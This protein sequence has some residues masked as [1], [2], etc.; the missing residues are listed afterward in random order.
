MTSF[1]MPYSQDA[2]RDPL[3]VGAQGPVAHVV[4]GGIGGRGGGRQ[5]ARGN[6]GRAALADG[7]QEGLP[8][9]LLVVD[10]GLD[11]LAIDGGVTVVGVHR[12]RVVAPDGQLLDGS[13]R[14][15]GLGGQLRGGTVVV[16][17]QHGGEVLGRQVRRRLHRDVGVGVGG[18]A[19]DQHLDVARGDGVQRLAL[20]RED[21]A[22]DGQQ[23]GTL[24]ARAA[25]TRA[26]QQ[27]VVGVLEGAHR[28]AVGFHAGQ[29]REGAVL[30]LHDHA[31]Q[32][33]L[34]L[35][36][37]DLQQLQDDGLVLAQH[38]AGGDAEQQGVADLASSAGDGDANGFLAH[39]SLRGQLIKLTSRGAKR[40]A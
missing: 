35:L 17:A 32:C 3:A 36:V 31:L 16:Q 39:G 38:L 30:E 9:P 14:L 8:V 27:R 22:V 23:L 5:A 19:D 11:R 25:R 4:D 6:D 7:G 34:G 1:G 37:G 40:A 2:H 15:A 12:R 24:H 20:R 28:V 18:V 21:G 13:D 29:Q 26:H 10:H 33:V